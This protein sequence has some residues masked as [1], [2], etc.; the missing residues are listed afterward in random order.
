[1]RYLALC[2]LIF[3][4]T[5]SYAQKK[6]L[7]TTNEEI[8]TA[9]TK[10]LDQSFVD[11]KLAKTVEKYGITGEYEYDITVGDKG[12]LQTIFTIRKEGLNVD[13]NRYLQYALRN[14]KYKTFKVPKYKSEKIRYKINID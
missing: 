3:T 9:V 4:T 11:G 12:E 8:M 10:E 1:M 6:P 7:L 13:Y 14:F 5:L 2:F